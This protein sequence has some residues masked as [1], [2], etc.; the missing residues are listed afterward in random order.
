[1]QISL[2]LLHGILFLEYVIFKTA[3]LKNELCCKEYM[4]IQSDYFKIINEIR[5][6]R[7]CHKIP[8]PLVEIDLNSRPLFQKSKPINFDI[9]FILEA[10]NRDDTVNPK[11]GYLT[12]DEFTD[13]S[14]RFF[15]KLLEDELKLNNNKLFFTNS[16][17]C[18]PRRNN[19]GKYP[20][21]SEILKKCN[22]HLMRF[23]LEF[24]PKIVCPLGNKALQATNNDLMERHNIKRMKDAVAKEIN[25]FGR[26]LFPL[27]HTSRISRNLNRSAEMQK[28]DWEKLAL[29]YNKIKAA[30]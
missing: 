19:E 6:C 1:M 2:F 5:E 21:K 16:V 23:I 25:W 17:L 13:P 29:L 24:N 7:E 30:T 9:L 10:P 12:V 26:I 11:K 4:V 22:K 3:L 20:V 27:Y 15:K 8:E 14:G 28:K 18:L